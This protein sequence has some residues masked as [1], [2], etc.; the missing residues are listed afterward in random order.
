MKTFI[1]VDPFLSEL[2]AVKIIG[3]EGLG[4]YQKIFYELKNHLN[5]LKLNSKYYSKI[6]NKNIISDEIPDT[7]NNLLMD[8]EE[9]FSFIIEA[10]KKN[11]NI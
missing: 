11:T 8:I 7:F 4:E 2:N 9:L 3:P 5:L 10:R 6:Y 1:N